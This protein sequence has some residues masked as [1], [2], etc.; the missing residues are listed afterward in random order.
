MT[1]TVGAERNNRLDIC[2]Q[3][4]DLPREPDAPPPFAYKARP[5]QGIWAT[6]P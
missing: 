6:A 2:Y 4:N 3:A 5:L 1:E